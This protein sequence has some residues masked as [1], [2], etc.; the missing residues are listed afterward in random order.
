MRSIGTIGF[1]DISY[2]LSIATEMNEDSGSVSSMVESSCLIFSRSSVVTLIVMTVESRVDTSPPVRIYG[3][4]SK[5]ILSVL[6][7]VKPVG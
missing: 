2:T 5:V 3:W 4:V 7:K 6:L 1:A